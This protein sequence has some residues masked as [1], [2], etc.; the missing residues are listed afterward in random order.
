MFAGAMLGASACK[1]SSNS[2]DTTPGGSETANEGGGDTYGGEAT[3]G[4]EGWGNP[5]EGYGDPCDGRG[6]GGGEGG[7]G[8]GFV[9]S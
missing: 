7:E 6:R 9:L 1:K 3:T 5:D 8:R 2:A 4:D